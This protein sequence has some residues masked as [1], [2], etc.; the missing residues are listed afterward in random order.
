MCLNE[1]Y[2]KVCVGKLLC[3]K[4]YIHNQLKQGD[5][6]SPLLFDL[7]LGYTVSFW[8]LMGHI[9]YWSILMMIICWATV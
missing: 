9:S 8:N 2:S 4:F 6:V 3:D 1:T 7:A 5:A